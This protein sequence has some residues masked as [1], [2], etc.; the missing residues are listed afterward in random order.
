MTVRNTSSVH[1]GDVG[2]AM[3]LGGE[4]FILHQEA[5]GQV[6]LV[7]SSVLPADMGGQREMFEAIGFRFGSPAEGDP[8][9]VHATLPPGWRMAPTDHAMGRARAK[10]FYKA[11]FYDRRADMHLVRRYSDKCDYGRN[12]FRCV[13]AAIVDG[14]TGEELWHVDEPS[15]DD[16]AALVARLK[17]ER[18][19]YDDLTAP[20]DDEEAAQRAAAKGA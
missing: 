14:A 3:V 1:A 12:P 5:Q 19:G 7:E 16:R 6:E 2:L 4:S 15:D 10:V 9:F 18:P 17:V 8:L 11:A 13:R 20:R